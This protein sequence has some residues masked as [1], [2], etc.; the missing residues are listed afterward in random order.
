ME[1]RIIQNNVGKRFRVAIPDEPGCIAAL[2]GRE[3]ERNDLA[4]PGWK[5]AYL[6]RTGTDKYGKDTFGVKTAIIST[7]QIIELYEPYRSKEIPELEEPGDDR[8]D[9]QAPAGSPEDDSIGRLET[10]IDPKLIPT[11][12]T[13]GFDLVTPIAVKVWLALVTHALTTPQ[14]EADYLQPG[15]LGAVDEGRGVPPIDDGGLKGCW[16]AEQLAKAVG[17]QPR[18]IHYALEELMQMNWLRKEKLRSNGGVILG[19]RYSILPPP[20]KLTT[21]ARK[22]KEQEANEKVQAAVEELRRVRRAK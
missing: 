18:S 15:A 13:G 20:G 11:V 19:F 17:K 10:A 4:E 5:V 1:T 22:I 6:V 14:P 9:S 21:I 2:L 3:P 12:S 7:E 16:T 8:Q